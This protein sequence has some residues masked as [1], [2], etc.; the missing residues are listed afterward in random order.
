MVAGAVEGTGVLRAADEEATEGWGRELGMGCEE[1]EEE[2]T[3]ACTGVRWVALDAG[4]STRSTFFSW[5]LILSKN[6][7][8]GF[9]KQTF[10]ETQQQISETK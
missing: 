6:K 1:E 9:S 5:W 7:I 3:V 2:F 4:G 10:A 8:S